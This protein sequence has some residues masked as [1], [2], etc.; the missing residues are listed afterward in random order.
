MVQG[1]PPENTG[2]KPEVKTCLIDGRGCF[3]LCPDNWASAHH[4]LHGALQTAAPG[5]VSGEGAG[6][7]IP[8]PKELQLLC[9]GVLPQPGID[10]CASWSVREAVKS[11]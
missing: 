9:C 1:I 2:L 7:T 5:K 8:G 10:F 11:L 4:N 6:L 3:L